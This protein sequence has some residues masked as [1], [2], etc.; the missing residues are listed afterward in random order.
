MFR[1][2]LIAT[3]VV[4]TGLASLAG[5]ASA[6]ESGHAAKGCSNAAEAAAKN[7]SGDSLGDTV[8]GGQTLDASN[9][10]DILNGNVIGSQNN[11]ATALG[12]IVNGDTTDITR[13]SSDTST[14]DR[15]TTVTPPA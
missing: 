3:A 7:S 6:H 8:G 1:K 15:S 10:C 9:T 4:G 11:V 2:T 12:T 14:V 13:T 5:I